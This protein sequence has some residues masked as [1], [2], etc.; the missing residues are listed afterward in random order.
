MTLIAPQNAPARP[1]RINLL[2]LAESREQLGRAAVPLS[3]LADPL[4]LP[5]GQAPAS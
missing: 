2:T 5:L 4:F 1:T 3:E